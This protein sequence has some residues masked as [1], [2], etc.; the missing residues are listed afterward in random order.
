MINAKYGDE[1]FVREQKKRGEVIE[2]LWKDI[3]KEYFWMSDKLTYK[4]RDGTKV[5]FW[6]DP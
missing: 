4:I 3:M 2:G 6:T 1:G 5:C